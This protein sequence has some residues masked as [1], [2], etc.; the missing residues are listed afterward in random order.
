MPWS[1][2]LKLLTQAALDAGS[3]A[4]VPARVHAMWV[5]FQDVWTMPHAAIDREALGALVR[6]V[7]V[8]FA[9]EQPEPK[10]SWLLPWDELTEPEREVDRRIGETV[11][12]YVLALVVTFAVTGPLPAVENAFAT[13]QNIIER[14]RREAAGP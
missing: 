1:N 8:A 9:S 13:F 6:D 5:E 2:K 10:A 11:G 4:R 7:W 14:R 3:L 12:V